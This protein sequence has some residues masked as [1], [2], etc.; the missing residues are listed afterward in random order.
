MGWPHWLPVK[1]MNEIL[2]VLNLEEKLWAC[3]FNEL[4]CFSS[5][6]QR[7]ITYAVWAKKTCELA[8][9]SDLEQ[10]FGLSVLGVDL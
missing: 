2:R 9:S 4:V 6:D 5:G 1:E 10:R 7:F 3:K 8:G